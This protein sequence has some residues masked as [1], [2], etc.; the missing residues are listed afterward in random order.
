M[1]KVKEISHSKKGIVTKR[2]EGEAFRLH[3]DKYD[4]NRWR[5]E[6]DRISSD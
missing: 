4:A 2:F 3:V 6:S 1:E 5:V